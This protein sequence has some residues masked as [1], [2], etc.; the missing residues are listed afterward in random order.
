[1]RVTEAKQGHEPKSM[2]KS[3]FLLIGV[4]R[5]RRRSHMMSAMTANAAILPQ[6]TPVI[7]VIDI[8]GREDKD[9][10]DEEVDALGNDDVLVIDDDV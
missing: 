8:R 9:D 2:R 7:T 4:R 6:S 3:G 5:R 10:D 1:M